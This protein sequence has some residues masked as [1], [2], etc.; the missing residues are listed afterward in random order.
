MVK[1]R[2]RKRRVEWRFWSKWWN[3]QPLVSSHLYRHSQAAV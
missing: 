3:E 1:G 2:S